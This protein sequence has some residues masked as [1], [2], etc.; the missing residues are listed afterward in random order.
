[1]NPG[2]KLEAEDSVWGKESVSWTKSSEEASE[3]GKQMM[4]EQEAP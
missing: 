4:S 3:Q 1:M 2:E